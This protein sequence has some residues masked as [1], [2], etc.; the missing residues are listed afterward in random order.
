MIDNEREGKNESVIVDVIVVVS[1]LVV[2]VCFAKV[3]MT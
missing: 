2:N 1:Y 3:R